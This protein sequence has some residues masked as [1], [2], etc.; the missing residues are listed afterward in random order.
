MAGI[1]N[2]TAAELKAELTAAIEQSR[3]LLGEVSRGSQDAVSL[4]EP[5]DR[6]T[7]RELSFGDQVEELG[8]K[9]HEQVD[10]SSF[11]DEELD[12]ILRETAPPGDGQVSIVEEFKR[13][14]T[15]KPMLWAVAAVAVGTWGAKA[16]GGDGASRKNPRQ[17]A[18]QSAET[19][20]THGSLMGHFMKTSFEIVQPLLQEAVQ[21]WL[22][23]FVEKN[24]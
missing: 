18:S 6:L 11:T 16:M 9:D 2:R 3:A 1:Q 5:V 20:I 23:R 21:G 12:I 8:H 17:N 10:F 4:E 22:R 15:A 24:S 14:I 19:A 13:Q 7:G